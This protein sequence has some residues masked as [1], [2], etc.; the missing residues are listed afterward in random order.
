MRRAPMVWLMAASAVVA[1]PCL[2]ASQASDDFTAPFPASPFAPNAEPATTHTYGG[3]QAAGGKSQDK[4]AA[5]PQQGGSL[6]PKG[7][8]DLLT[9]FGPSP[10]PNLPP[11]AAAGA[12]ALTEEDQGQKPVE[13][14]T[15]SS[16]E[17]KP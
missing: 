5:A 15:D 13:A 8:D 6:L 9:W 11:P 12:T 3:L 1:W 17:P 4:A 10:F 14:Q 2:A 7:G 16:A